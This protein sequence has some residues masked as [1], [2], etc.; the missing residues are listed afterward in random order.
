MADADSTTI[1]IKTMHPV[2][3]VLQGPATY[4]TES[5]YSSTYVEIP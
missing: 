1:Y 5:A 4:R 2:I 3:W